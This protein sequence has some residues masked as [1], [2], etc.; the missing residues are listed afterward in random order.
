MAKDKLTDYSATNA[1]NTDIGGINIDEGMLPSAVNNALR[2]LLT[3]LKEFSDGTSGIDVLSLADDDASAAMKLQAPASVTSD[4]TLTLPDGDGDSGQTLITNGSGTLAWAAPYGNRNLI[5]NG[6]MQVAQRG[7]SS[8]S[9][10]YQ[11]VDRFN[12]HKNGSFDQL[13]FTQ[14]QVT[15]APAG[16]SNS[17]KF[18]TT[19]AETTVDADE[20]I[21]IRTALEGQDLQQLGYGTGSAKK[22]TLSFYVKSS[23]TGTFAIYFYSADTVRIITRTYT[24]SSAN[25]WEQKSVTIDGD[26]SGSIDNDANESLQ[27]SWAIAAG[28]NFTSSD[29]TSWS[30]YSNAKLYYD[31]AQN[32]VLTTTNATWQITGVQL[33]LGE[34][35]TPFE[36][37]SFGDEL[38]KCQRYYS[39]YDSTNGG[40]VGSGFFYN[41]TAVE[42]TIRLPQRMR[43]APTVSIGGTENHIAIQ[44]AATSNAGATSSSAGNVRTVAYKFATTADGSSTTGNGTN[45]YVQNTAILKHDAE[46]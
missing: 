43:A 29:S 30:A 5:I 37:R 7:T 10:G 41:T 12:V 42:V 45:L 44:R 22:L 9:L 19:T 15:D 38:I 27:I 36:H 34:Q 33:E 25:T 23:Q 21:G 16:F 2:E 1:S 28:S 46:L 26:A 4:T 8:T 3:H 13:A 35:A 18:T 6:A 32:A 20:S 24:I 14:A 11:T 17:Y 39:Q 31:H 40:W